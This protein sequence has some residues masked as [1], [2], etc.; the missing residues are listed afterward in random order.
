VSSFEQRINLYIGN[1]IKQQRIEYKLSLKEVGGY[2]G[3]SYQQLQKYENG[4]NRISA[5]KLK[6]I[7]QALDVPINY[8][9]GS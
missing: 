5:A 1:K 4:Q 3:V 2:V 9:Y 6:M 8:F 7:S